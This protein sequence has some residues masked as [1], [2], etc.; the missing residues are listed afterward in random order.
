MSTIA[1]FSN[2]QKVVHGIQNQDNLNKILT[3]CY[4]NGYIS[5]F[6]KNFRIG[7]TTAGNERQFYA[8]FMIQFPNRD[9]WIIFS[10]TS[11]RTDR[12]KGQQWD[13]MNLKNLDSTITTAILAYPSNSVDCD[14]F[15]Q[16]DN[17]YTTNME[18]SAIDRVVS[19]DELKQ[20]I[21]KEFYNSIQEEVVLSDTD[22]NLE[23][24]Q[25]IEKFLNN[26]KI[27]DKEGKNFETK[28][29]QILSDPTYLKKYL[30]NVPC[31]KGDDYFLFY[32]ML[33]AFKL[34]SENICKI[35]ATSKKEDIGYLPSG[36]APKTDVIAT[37][38][39]D[40]KTEQIITISC[41]RSKMD[42]VT[43]HQYNA[44]TFAD[45]LDSKNE[46]LRNRL[47][48]FQ[49]YGNVRDMPADAA[50]ELTDALKPYLKQLVLWAIGGI[51]GDGDPETQWAQYIISHQTTKDIF[52]VHDVQEYYEIVKNKINMFGTPMQ[53]TYASKSKG[54]N[55]QLKAPI[56]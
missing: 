54:K 50:T 15:K 18:I 1:S 53:W 48:D 17:R 40:D 46:I 23:S 30:K 42:N 34:K 39:F 28:I 13:A 3:Q 20:I 36:G 52:S 32:Q 12:I 55:I 16:Q 25:Q 19:F 27:W 7:S 8:P 35:Y 26:G 41:K 37:F 38:V 6:Q 29:A 47:K 2:R 43:V 33:S 56:V 24:L 10:S 22:T 51:G 45:V 4:E 49:H 31:E 21:Q 44:D 9:R 14:K 5:D 11:M